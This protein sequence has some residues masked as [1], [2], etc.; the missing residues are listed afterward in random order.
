MKWIKPALLA[1][2]LLA[3]TVSGAAWAHGGGHVVV[4]VGVPLGGWGW[5]WG[6]GGPWGYPPAYYYYPPYGYAPYYGYG[7]Y[8]YSSSPPVY[9]EQGGAQAAPAQ[10]QPTSNYWYYCSNPQ[11]YYPYV[12]ECP[13]G[14]Q[15]VAPQPPGH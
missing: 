13:P 2:L 11:G 3:A 8:G 6:W 12:K 4:G 7:G 1:M 15:K 14:W 10:Q 5:G 9:I